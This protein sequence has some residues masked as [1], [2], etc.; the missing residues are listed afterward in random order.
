MRRATVPYVWKIND[1]L[2]RGRVN[3]VNFWENGLAT[4]YTILTEALE[5]MVNVIPRSLNRIAQLPVLFFTIIFGRKSLQPL[6]TPDYNREVFK[7]FW[8]DILK[9][10]LSDL[11][12]EIGHEFL[13]TLYVKY[14]SACY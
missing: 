5:R 2:L 6:Y 8:T 11:N 13:Q 9:N 3:I 7:D 10:E 12:N 14:E 1:F 4:C